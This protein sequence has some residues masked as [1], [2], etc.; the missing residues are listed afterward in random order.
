MLG[1]VLFG[2]NGKSENCMLNKVTLESRTDIN[3][4]VWDIESHDTV[5][6]DDVSVMA[7][8]DKPSVEI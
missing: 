2:W 3:Q 7:I 6:K 1:W 5:F 8:E 4:N